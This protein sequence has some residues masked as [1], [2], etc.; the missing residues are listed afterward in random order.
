MDTCSTSAAS[1]TG[2]HHNW[3]WGR[4]LQNIYIYINSAHK[5]LLTFLPKIFAK[6]EFYAKLFYYKKG[7]T[8]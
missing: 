7:K 1:S 3:D 6:L 2:P 4:F 8:L 5:V